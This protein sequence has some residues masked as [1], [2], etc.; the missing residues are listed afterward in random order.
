MPV[1]AMNLPS[2]IDADGQYEIPTPVLEILTKLMVLPPSDYIRAR[3]YLAPFPMYFEAVRRNDLFASY[4]AQ[5]VM[6]DYYFWHLQLSNY[7]VG[8]SMKAI[9]TPP[10]KVQN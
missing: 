4:F 6:K 10:K 8:D 2:Y 5:T 7:I 9:P 1:Q 3:I